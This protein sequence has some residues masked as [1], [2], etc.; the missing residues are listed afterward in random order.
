MEGREAG[1]HR[2]EGQR[3]G[4]KNLQPKQAA[5]MGN[6]GCRKAAELCPALS[7]PS[8]AATALCARG[9][10]AALCT[11]TVPVAHVS[12]IYKKR[13]ALNFGGL[14]AH[15]PIEIIA[16]KEV[17][18]VWWLSQPSPSLWAAPAG[19]AANEN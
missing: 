4:H 17:G 19:C 11:H 1:G 12:L 16:A 13:W 2:Q 6:Q 5:I 8:M 18:A 14:V 10:E 15:E 3:V 9:K 7:V